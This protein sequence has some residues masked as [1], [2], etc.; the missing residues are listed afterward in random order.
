MKNYFLTKEQA[1][2]KIQRMAY[3]ISEQNADKP[4][5]VLAGIKEQGVIIANKLKTFL[6]PL[7]TKPITV[8]EVRLDKK[9]P[10][11]IKLSEEADFSQAGIILIDDV[12]NSGKTML[13]ALQP[14][15]KYYPHQIQ[16]LALVER[17]HK[18]YPVHLDY[19]GM[20]LATTFQ[21]HIFVELDQSEIKGAWLE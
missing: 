13:Y 3:E 1:E 9:H 6:E 2:M 15:L 12:A 7:Y 18:R 11:E 5:L 21:E 19:V 16:T 4:S 20:S 17:T 14:F 8:I 10:V